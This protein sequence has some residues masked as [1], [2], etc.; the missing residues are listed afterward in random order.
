MATISGQKKKVKIVRII[1]RLNIGGPAIHTILLSSAL[2][3]G[4][5]EDVLVCG[6]TAGSEGDMLHLAK[7]NNVE[8]VLIPEL[9][10]D[11][12]F[13]NDVT[14]FLKLYSLIKKERPDIVHTHTAKA[15]TLGRLAAIFNGVPVRIHTFHGHVFDGYFS[16]FKA[17]LFAIIERALACFTDKIV[18][19]S[20]SVKDDIVSKLKIVKGYKCAVIRL[21][22]DLGKFLESSKAAWSFRRELGIGDDVIVVGIV[23]R[24]VPI[25]NHKMFLDAVHKMKSIAPSAKVKFLIIGDGELKDDLKSYAAKLNL[26]D[27]VI[28]TGWIKDLPRV[29][30]SLDIVALTSLNEGTPVSIIEAMA[31]G[32]PV[33]A[34][35]VGGVRDLIEDGGNG[36][37]V[38][39]NDVEDFSYKL[40]G[41]FDDKEKRERMGTS[42]MEFVR[43]IYSKERM[44]RDIDNLYTECLKNKALK[45]KEES[46]K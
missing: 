4:G 38:K 28:F 33:V 2:N 42:G 5:Y 39:S 13:R 40:T 3:A 21:G 9:G 12:S 27:S 46:D 36:F 37:L 6:K 23:G 34:T 19:V 45:S 7:D 35:D 43:H 8:P 20:E 32:K 1:T 14:S 10:R 30:S 16:P 31:S 41:L 15:G 22:L 26:G 17:K 44:V 18:V 29:Y 25:K 11:I 24:L